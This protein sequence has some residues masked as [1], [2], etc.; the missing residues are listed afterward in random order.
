MKKRTALFLS[1]VLILLSFSAL[2]GC[3][4]S[5]PEA[6]VKGFMEAVKTMDSDEMAKYCVDD[7]SGSELPASDDED[8]QF[9]MP[10]FKSLTYKIVST[11]KPDDVA[12]VTL[13]IT[14]LNAKDAITSLLSELMLT[15]L[16]HM[17]DDDFD[18]DAYYAQRI[19]EALSREDL[20]TVTTTVV[21]DLVKSEDGEWLVTGLDDNSEF[22]DAMTG[23]LLSAFNSLF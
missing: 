7:G 19:E 2:S 5:S 18:E 12:A 6:A 14:T 20:D 17:G 21:L 9:I 15:A 11:E 16:S 10:I 1:F 23:G 8:A 13:E 3:Q 22:L 4:K